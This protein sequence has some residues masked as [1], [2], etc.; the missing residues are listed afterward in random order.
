MVFCI[1][2]GVLCSSYFT[3]ENGYHP[4]G[5][6]HHPFVANLETG[7]AIALANKLH[8]VI[9]S[10]NVVVSFFPVLRPASLK[11]LKWTGA[12]EVDGLSLVTKPENYLRCPNVH[13][14]SHAGNERDEAIVNGFP[15]FRIKPGDDLRLGHFQFFRPMPGKAAPVLSFF[16]FRHI[17]DSRPPGG[18]LPSSSI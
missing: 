5:T 11:A 13:D 6:I 7:P 14:P 1:L 9:L 8:N 12:D 15:Y 3:I 16:L 10:N 17:I 4:C 18:E 2:Y